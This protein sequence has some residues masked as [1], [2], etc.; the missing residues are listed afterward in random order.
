M[1]HFGAHAWVNGAFPGGRAF[2]V[3]AMRLQ[4]HQDIG[5]S[6]AAVAQDDQLYPATVLHVDLMSAREDCG[7]P[8]RIVL[9]SELGEMEIKVTDT[10]NSFPYSM[11][12]PFD[13]TVGRVA[14]ARPYASLYDEFA[15]VRWGDLQGMGWTERGLAPQPLV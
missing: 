4:G 12:E 13:T 3:Y 6:N 8:H 11:V 1:G 9:R 15:R 5:M 7:R 10:L 2:Y 14:H